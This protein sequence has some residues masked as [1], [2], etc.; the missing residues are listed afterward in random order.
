MP[1]SRSIEVSASARLHF[2]LWAWGAGHERQ[3]G[4]V[5]MMVREPRLRVLFR[6]AT[7]FSATGLATQRV[8]TIVQRCAQFWS[9]PTLPA[10][11]IEVDQLPPQ[12]A[13]F[14]VGTQLALAVAKGLATW[15]GHANLS[16]Q[17]LAVA[18]GRGLRSAVGTYGF[19]TGGLIVDRGKG[20]DDAIGELHCHAEVP[21]AWRVLLLTPKAGRGKAGEAERSAFAQLP[22]ATV[23]SNPLP[24]IPRGRPDRPS[25]PGCRLRPFFRRRVRVRIHRRHLLRASPGWSLC[26][27]AGY[28]PRERP[29]GYGSG[30]RRAEFLGANRLRFCTQ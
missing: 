23:R 16:E 21:E 1:H 6:D 2:G 17:Q 14:G 15:S 3:F 7:D 28:S 5:G 30:R 13:G 29:A 24:P 19:A 4:G 26:H 12:H 18:T 8:Q 27:S 20:P 9:M 22:P 11:S 25:L 10:C